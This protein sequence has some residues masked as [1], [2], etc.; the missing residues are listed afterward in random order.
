MEKGNAHE[1][2]QSSEAS[3]Q[4]AFKSPISWLFVVVFGAGMEL[5]I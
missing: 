3:C 2:H 1:K 4:R 5:S